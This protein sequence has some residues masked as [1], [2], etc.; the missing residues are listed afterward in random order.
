MPWRPYNFSSYPMLFFDH[1]AVAQQ[2]AQ[3]LSL[4]AR[5]SIAVFG[6]MFDDFV[7][8]L[9]ERPAVEQ[10]QLIHMSSL[11]FATRVRSL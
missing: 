9:H 6:Q 8:L 10:E 5:D 1:A 3:A 11:S 2:L 7:D 4:A